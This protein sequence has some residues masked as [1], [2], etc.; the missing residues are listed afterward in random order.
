MGKDA[1]PIKEV[2]KGII[3]GL[4]QERLS[5]EERV[6]RVWQKA[7]GKRFLPHTRPTSFR[8]KRLVVEVD[9]SGWLYELTMEKKGIVAKLKKML[10]DDFRELQF[11]I[12]RVE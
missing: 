1:A 11:R 8:K 4:S 5:K 9:S 2:A 3:E 12:G 10:G 6:K 7:V